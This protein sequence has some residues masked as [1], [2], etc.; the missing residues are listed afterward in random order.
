MIKVGLFLGKEEKPEAATDAFLRALNAG[1]FEPSVCASGKDAEGLDVLIV[2]GGDGTILHAVGETAGKPI[3]I[4]GVNFG[5][6]GFLAEFERDETEELVA[7]L[8]EIERGNGAV[9]N[10]SMLEISLGGNAYFA[11]NEVAFQRDYAD[12][13]SRIMRTEVTINGRESVS[14]RGDGALICTPT[15]STAYALSAGGAILDPNAAVFML[16]PVCSFSLNARPIVVPDACEMNLKIGCS[17]AAVLVDGRLV[18]RMN[19]GDEVSVKKAPF[20]AVFPVRSGRGFYDKVCKKL[21]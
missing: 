5:T 8:K 6:L 15:G 21:K 18:G 19:D 12:S 17:S 1:G 7:F 13:T 16:T 10:R 3:Q 2:L 14:F 20:S 4:V 9:L 11:L